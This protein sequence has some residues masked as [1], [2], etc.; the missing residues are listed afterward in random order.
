MNQYA[1]ADL[2]EASESATFTESNGVPALVSY[3]HAVL[4]RRW[5]ILAIVVA[6]AALGMV[7]SLLATPYYKATARIQIDRQGE[8]VTNVQEVSKV[9]SGED[10]EFYQTQYALLQARSLAERVARRLNLASNAHFFE[11]FGRDPGAAASG[12]TVAAGDRAAQLRRASDLLVEH[13][14]I[15]PIRGSSLV[16]IQFESPDPDMSAQIANTYVE[17]FIASTLGRRFD[18]TQDARK[19]LETR[20][21]DLREKM[22]TSERE[23]VNYAAS[24]GIVTLSQNQDAGGLSQPDKTLT[25]I[26]LEALN[27]ALT[28]ATEARIAAESTLRAQRPS[29]LS[30]PTLATLRQSRADAAAQLAQ[31]SARFESGYP[32][33]QAAQSRL[34]TLDRAI[35]EETSR[36][37]T[38]AQQAYDAARSREAALQSRVN[39]L[40]TSLTGEKAASIQYNIYQREVDTNRHHYD[41]LLQRYK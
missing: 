15:A 28:N 13:L 7:L 26:D 10:Q 2:T 14:T 19:F 29:R 17:E 8:Q 31:L 37:G 4:R 41:A 18:S 40:K 27:Q 11:M 35:A 5:T 34:Q 21:A 23:L 20:L 3:W 39:A 24:Q 22:E 30:N 33:V 16:D 9:D 12:N 1:Y 6:A 36:A 32:E 25:S 38:E